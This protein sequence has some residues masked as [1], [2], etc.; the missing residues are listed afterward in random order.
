MIPAERLKLSHHQS[1]CGLEE[2]RQGSIRLCLPVPKYERSEHGEHE[3]YQT[4]QKKTISQVNVILIR[5]R[6]RETL[7]RDGRAKTDGAH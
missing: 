3:S 1:I 6:R 2:N 4:P 5:S 7:A